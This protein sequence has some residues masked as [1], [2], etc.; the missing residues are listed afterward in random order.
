MVKLKGGGGVQTPC[1][2]SVSHV[3][4]DLDLNLDSGPGAHVKMGLDL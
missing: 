2:S 4:C 1:P 3:D